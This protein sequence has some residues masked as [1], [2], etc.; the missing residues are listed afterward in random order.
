MTHK[1]LYIDDL[2]KANANGIIVGLQKD[3]IEITYS[4][5]KGDWE[6]EIKRLSEQ[7]KNYQGIIFDLRLQE[8]KK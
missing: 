5:P 3:S 8:K 4:N 1:F 6:E 2:D 7:A